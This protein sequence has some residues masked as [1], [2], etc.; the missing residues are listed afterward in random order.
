M[1]VGVGGGGEDTLK[2]GRLKE[3]LKKEK[4]TTTGD[5]RE[6]ES[7][8]LESP[9]I[10]GETRGGV[11]SAA[12]RSEPVVCKSHLL[13]VHPIVITFSV[14]GGGAASARPLCIVIGSSA[15]EETR[16]VLRI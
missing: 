12:P 14:R 5:D 9:L 3:T 15:A 10:C 13:L 2:R 7:K 4:G 16:A 8:V 1:E 11:L 6:T